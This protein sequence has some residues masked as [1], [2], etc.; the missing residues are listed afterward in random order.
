MFYFIEYYPYVTIGVC[1][2]KTENI[3]LKELSFVL[4]TQI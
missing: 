1:D 3:V 4:V 2:L